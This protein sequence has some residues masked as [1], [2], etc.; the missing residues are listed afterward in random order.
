MA[1]ND[2]QTAADKDELNRFVTGLGRGVAGALF[3]ALP[4]LMTMEMWHLG[5][6]MARERL[7]LLL[8]LDIPLLILLAHRI[9]FEET[10]GWR[11]AIRDAAIAYGIGIL[12][13]LVV[14]T[15][16]GLLRG[17]M[18]ASELSG[19][20]ALQ[21]VPASIGAMLGRSQLGH[22]D[23]DTGTKETSY[24]GE[25]LLM[26][27]GALFL[28]LNIAP[29]DEMMVLAYKM[30]VWHALAVALISIALMHGFVYAVSFTGGHELSPQ[31]P[32]WHAFVRFTLPGYVIAL[33]ISIFALWIF[34]RLG[35]SAP[36]EVALSVIVLGFPAALG[37]AAAR[38]IL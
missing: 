25:L 19:K 11:E 1:R 4:M 37:A 27:A 26:A 6:S 17:G 24:A 23:D 10:F 5:F 13:S 16:L 3:L 15:A 22:D 33:A 18:P 30:T 31:T 35:G 9:G 28:S 36:V 21:S 14:L 38:L 20:V 29:T 32:W 8:L 2:A 7:F 12:T 34:E